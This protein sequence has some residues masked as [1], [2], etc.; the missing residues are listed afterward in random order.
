[1]VSS[2]S[3]STSAAVTIVIAVPTVESGSGSRVAVVT[4]GSSWTGAYWALAAEMAAPARASNRP[5]RLAGLMRRFM[6]SA[7]KEGPGEGTQ[8]AALTLHP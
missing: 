8:G 4:T 1:M 3:R 2:C 6:V 5:A 7:G